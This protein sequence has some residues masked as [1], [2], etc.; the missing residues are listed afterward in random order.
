MIDPVEIATGRRDSLFAEDISRK[1]EDIRAT[2]HERRV[3]VIGGAGSIGSATVRALLEYRPSAVH[4]ID[5]NENGLA[6]LVRDLR[7]SGLVDLAVDLKLMPLD[8]GASVSRRFISAAG[9]Y[10]VVLHFAA[11]KHVRSEKDVAAILQMIDTN[12]LKQQ[13]LMSWLGESTPPSHYFAVSTDKA[14]NPVSFMGASKRLMEHLIFAESLAPLDASVRTSARFAN[15]AFSAGSLLASFPERIQRRQPIAVPRSTR[16]FFVS[17]EEAAHICL[18][19][20]AAVPSGHI[21]IPRMQADENL[22][23]LIP[24]AE[25]FLR[26]AGLRPVSYDDEASARA[27]VESDSANGGWPML[28]TPR[29][30]DGEKESEVFIGEGETPIEIGMSALLAIE[31]AA[32]DRSSLRDVLSR[33]QSLVDDSSESITKREI[34]E[35]VREVVPEFNPLESGVQLDSRM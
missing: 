26:S 25:G 18:L 15:V 28:L 35:L 29:N 24:I 7:G 31:Q 9:P 12:V 10:D 8:Y 34:A 13:R 27:A 20:C 21:A 30:T 16:R 4:V 32:A 11:L 3:L 1:G 33:L 22:R 6:E 14:A 19:A 23:E 17:V 5:Q 2:F